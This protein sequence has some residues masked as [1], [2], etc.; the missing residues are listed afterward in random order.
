MNACNSTS[1]CYSVVVATV[2]V[3]QAAVAAATST[4][5]GSQGHHHTTTC[6]VYHTLHQDNT[7]PLPDHTT[8]VQMD[9][10]TTTGL[11]PGP[12]NTTQDGQNV[13]HKS[14]YNT[15]SGQSQAQREQDINN[16]MKQLNESSTATCIS[17]LFN[18]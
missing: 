17:G 1:L 7:L 6:T 4:F 11:T 2:H 14:I 15:L 10:E 9:T 16:I 12:H 18:P 3:Y 13:L 5:R 8:H